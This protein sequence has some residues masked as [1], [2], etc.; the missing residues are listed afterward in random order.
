MRKSNLLKFKSSCYILLLGIINLFAFSFIFG[1]A[2][3]ANKNKDNLADSIAR[4]NKI[5]D[6]LAKEKQKQDSIIEIKRVQDSIIREDSIKK[7]KQMKPHYKPIKP[8]MKY[9]VVPTGYK[10]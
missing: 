2:N 7:A 5:N 10:K 8:T 1:C 9:G 4:A 6:S 3:N